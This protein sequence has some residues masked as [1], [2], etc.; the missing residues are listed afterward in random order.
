MK[1]V[2]HK[3]IEHLDLGRPRSA[4]DILKMRG[5][6]N[7]TISAAIARTLLLNEEQ[8]KITWPGHLS[9]ILT[10]DEVVHRV[11]DD[12]LLRQ[13]VKRLSGRWRMLARGCK[14]TGTAGWFIYRIW[15]DEKYVDELSE[16]MEA[17]C[18]NLVVETSHPAIILQR[19]LLSTEAD[20][21]RVGK[22]ERLAYLVK[23]W[24]AFILNKTIKIFTYRKFG[25]SREEFP[26]LLSK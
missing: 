7:H 1:G 6:A 10:A 18:E 13:V 26:T 22:E 15:Q 2:D 14:A 8:E 23:A 3:T 11:L 12:A 4:S 17:F 20:S 9:S 5:I 16:F 19:K 21:K 24:N 25:P